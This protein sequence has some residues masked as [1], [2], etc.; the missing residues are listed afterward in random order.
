MIIY[1][2]PLIR[3]ILLTTGPSAHASKKKMLPHRSVALTIF[4]L[5]IN[6]E[7]DNIP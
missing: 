2:P 4:K 6:T 5:S 3:N 1:F 7:V